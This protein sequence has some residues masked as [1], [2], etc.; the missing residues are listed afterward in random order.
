[1]KKLIFIYILYNIKIITAL[2]VM[3]SITYQCSLLKYIKLT[4][5]VKNIG[6]EPLNEIHIVN[7]HSKSTKKIYSIAV[8]KYTN[9][10]SMS[11]YELIEKAE[12]EEE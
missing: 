1:M 9:Y 4:V 10:F 8:A 3:C 5:K 2:I 11:L 7:N 6:N 12:L